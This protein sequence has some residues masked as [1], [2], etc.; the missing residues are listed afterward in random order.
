M[1]STV[2][3]NNLFS[4]SWQNVYDLVNNRS[5]VA[6]P[7]TASTSNRKWVYT[8]DPDVKSISFK[9]FPY[10]I[11]YPTNID[12]SPE[13]TVDGEKKWVN[14]GVEIEVVTCD[15]GFNNLDGKGQTHI[16]AIS[17]DIA[18]T[19]NKTSNRNTLKA[20]GLYF[21]RPDSTGVTVEEFNNTLVYRRSFILSFRSFK[22]VVS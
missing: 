9:G 14:W 20:N 3:Y 22:K 11:V 19:F 7:T 13:Q 21:F 1:G 6:D 18:E 2:N 8:R 4:E 15:R 12:F 17:D 5:N 10:M 16:D